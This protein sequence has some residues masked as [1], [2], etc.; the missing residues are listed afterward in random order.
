MAYKRHS[1][2]SNDSEEILKSPVT[3]MSEPC[4]L[5]TFSR[6]EKKQSDEKQRKNS[7]DRLHSGD[8]RKLTQQNIYFAERHSSHTNEFSE[9]KYSIKTETNFSDIK[10][11]K[12]ERQIMSPNLMKNEFDE[13]M[14]LNSFSSRTIEDWVDSKKICMRDN[15]EVEKDAKKF[16]RMDYNQSIKDSSKQIK[17]PFKVYNKNENLISKKY[18]KNNKNL[19]YCSNDEDKSVS[20]RKRNSMSGNNTSLNTSSRRKEKLK[21]KERTKV[22]SISSASTVKTFDI[23]SKNNAPSD[24]NLKYKKTLKESEVRE[25]VSNI[26]KN[27]EYQKEKQ[28]EEPKLEESKHEIH[29]KNLDDTLSSIYSTIEENSVWNKRHDVSVVEADGILDQINSRMMK[30]HFEM[31]YKN[32]DKEDGKISDFSFEIDNT[33]NMIVP[34]NSNAPIKNKKFVQLPHRVDLYKEQECS[35]GKVKWVEDTQTIRIFSHSP[36]RNTNGSISSPFTSPQTNPRSPE[37]QIQSPNS[38]LN[39]N[40][41]SRKDQRVKLSMYEYSCTSTQYYE[42]GLVMKPSRAV[43][44]PIKEVKDHEDNEKD[45]NDDIEIEREL[46]YSQKF[47]TANDSKS[48]L[49]QI[50]RSFD[51]RFSEGTESI[52]TNNYSFISGMSQ[53]VKQGK[54]KRFM[55]YIFSKIHVL[56]EESICLYPSLSTQNFNRFYKPSCFS[57]AYDLPIG[58]KLEKFEFI[59]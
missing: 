42:N 15:K 58:P 43:K 20:Y 19:S 32:L 3:L 2:K 13:G 48:D 39:P 26:L 12:R 46:E 38:T 8:P 11:G 1:T 34:K 24:P 23:L 9:K 17:V 50:E 40:H 18:K 54:E 35:D 30:L 5:D 57:I 37:S 41:R 28:I 10:S 44:S 21:P 25:Q 22:R 49:S 29:M 6:Y 51:S 7:F 14:N 27:F 36:T 56:E 59:N 53:Y 31:I 4:Y 47:I 33:N 52:N 16:Y 45:R 55:K